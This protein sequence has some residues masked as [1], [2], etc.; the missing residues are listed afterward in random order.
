M[1]EQQKDKEKPKEDDGEFI[2]KYGRPTINGKD[3]VYKI[4]K[5]DDNNYDL[6]T[7]HTLLSNILQTQMEKNRKKM[8]AINLRK[9]YSFDDDG[10]D[11]DMDLDDNQFPKNIQA[12]SEPQNDFKDMKG[13]NENNHTIKSEN[14]L[15]DIV[16]QVNNMD[17]KEVRKENPINTIAQEIGDVNDI[18]EHGDIGNINKEN[19][20]NENIIE[21]NIVENNENKLIPSNG[22]DN[23]NNIINTTDNMNPSVN[24]NALDNII[25]E[26]KE[27]KKEAEQAAQQAAEQAAQQTAQQGQGGDLPSGAN[28]N[29]EI[30][31]PNLENNNNI[32]LENPEE[33]KDPNKPLELTDLQ[34]EI[35]LANKDYTDKEKKKEEAKLNPKP[36]KERKKKEKKE[37]K[38]KR[39]YIKKKRG[40]PQTNFTYR[41]NDFFDTEVKRN[42][43]NSRKNNPIIPPPIPE[44]QKVA[45]KKRNANLSTNNANRKKMNIKSPKKLKKNR[46]KNSADGRNYY[47]D[48]SND[49]NEINNNQNLLEIL[50]K[51]YGYN[52]I[53]YVLTGS[54]EIK[55]GENKI[56]K[57]KNSI[58]NLLGRSTN[59]TK[60]IETIVK[61]KKNNLIDETWI[62]GRYNYRTRNKNN[63]NITTY[64][65][66]LN[67]DNYIYKYKAEKTMEDG[68]IKFKCCD[69]KCFGSGYLF[70]RIKVFKV[71]EEH[72]IPPLH[73]D[74]LKHGYD[75]FQFKM[76]N[77][78]WN[79]MS[80]K[81]NPDDK[82]SYIDW[83][84]TTVETKTI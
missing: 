16:L 46:G 58:S 67:N 23:N 20:N 24:I 43:I 83:H 70:P 17:A 42:L 45:P 44:P 18:N 54:P 60:I 10:Q 76:E 39:T 26:I 62:K 15:M 13:I 63:Y 29:S 52:N 72:S 56:K 30:N 53:I 71:T 65:Y 27:E 84:R 21:N 59:I 22:E 4:K 9:H 41:L 64:H 6:R 57:I 34:K 7:T 31:P 50:F 36:K 12:Y 79:E 37:K 11:D 1:T 49:E 73:H 61:M 8:M 69:S 81:V 14:N 25:D 78:N 68:C 77:E 38:E 3:T 28:L 19:E 47:G 74:Y 33:K 75:N 80:L 32:P 2:I 40:R 66:K 48:D 82:K 35:E 51:E 55:L 5:R